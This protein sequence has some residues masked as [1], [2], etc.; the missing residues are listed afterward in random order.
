MYYLELFKTSQKETQA[1]EKKLAIKH[2]KELEK[3]KLSSVRCI[4]NMITLSSIINSG[5]I[6]VS[7]EDD[8]DKITG[9][10][11]HFSQ[12]LNN[13]MNIDG[14]DFEWKLEMDY[15]IKTWTKLV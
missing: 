9:S 10:V 15:F 3:A 12:S 5:G 6:V 14:G 7:S 4:A 2:E 11:D 8:A 1:N 13:L